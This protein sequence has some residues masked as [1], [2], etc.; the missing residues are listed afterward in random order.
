MNLINVAE[1]VN[2]SCGSR[3]L[4]AG[5]SSETQGTRSVHFSKIIWSARA[6]VERTAKTRFVKTVKS[7][8]LFVNHRHLA[9]TLAHWMASVA[10]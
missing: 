6:R 7:E 4:C 10:K 8:D 3:A 1:L 5:V 9:L 2:K